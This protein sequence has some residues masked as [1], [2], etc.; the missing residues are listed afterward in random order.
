MPAAVELTEQDTETVRAIA[1]FAFVLPRPEFSD[2][3]GPI[4]AKLREA[5]YQ[6][7]LLNPDQALALAQD[8]HTGQVQPPK[9]VIST[10]E[11]EFISG[12][13]RSAKVL[14]AH[15]FFIRDT[16]PTPIEQGADHYFEFDYFFAPS[17]FYAEWTIRALYDANYVGLGYANAMDHGIT[18]YVI[19]GGYAKALPP[20]RKP[21]GPRPEQPLILYAPSVLSPEHTGH[22]FHLDG[23]QIL[24]SLAR[25][26]PH[27]RIVC[28]PHPSD[29]T[30]DFVPHMMALFASQGMDNV[31]F[32]LSVTP[33]PTLYADPDVL[34]TDMSGFA[35]VYEMLTRQRP[36]FFIPAD[37]C[38]KHPRFCALTCQFA[39]LVNNVQQLLDVVQAQLN[40]PDVLEGDVAALFDSVFALPYNTVDA[41]MADLVRIHQGERAEHWINL[42]VRYGTQR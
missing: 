3:I 9:V 22:R 34:L 35:F 14:L 13:T 42:P 20:A 23:N 28:R 1:D 30:R 24:F 6:C 7:M 18:K 17:T 12:F 11:G 36:I 32:D 8:C 10:N 29:R 2:F 21:G 40:Q 15:S 37:E 4:L 39:R 16:I 31:S 33:P 5:G 26:F 19:P 41:L 38:A 25:A 27:A